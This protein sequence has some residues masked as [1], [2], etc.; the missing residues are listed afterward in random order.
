MNNSE[1]RVKVNGGYLI[2]GRNP[3][4][5]YDG[6]YIEFETDNGDIVDVVVAECTAQDDYKKINVY[7]YEDEWTEDWTRKYTLDI[8]EINKAFEKW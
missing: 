7:T 2:A 4:P 8:Q 1:I 3:D 6:I 5:D